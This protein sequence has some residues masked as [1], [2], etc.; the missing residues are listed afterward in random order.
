MA[1]GVP[2]EAPAYHCIDVPVTTR[3]ASV[4][5]VAAQ[6]VWGELPVGAEGGLGIALIVTAVVYAELHSPDGVTLN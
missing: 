4:G 6:N 1:R 3:L 2:P 5:A